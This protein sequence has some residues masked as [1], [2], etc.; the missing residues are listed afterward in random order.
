M[1]D[2]EE[3]EVFR[4]HFDEC[5]VHFREGFAARVPRG[6][7][8]SSR[9]K[10]PIADFCGV[11]IPTVTSWLNE[12]CLPTGDTLIRLMFYLELVGYKIIELERMPKTRRYFAELIGFGVLSGQEATELVGYHQTSELYIVLKGLQDA[13]KRKDEIMWDAW[14]ERR[15]ELEQKKEQ[16]RQLCS[17][18][19]IPPANRLEIEEAGHEVF[20]PPT[21]HPTAII[22]IMSA[23]LALLED[24]ADEFLKIVLANPDSADTMLHLSARLS[25]LSSQIMESA[26]LRRRQADE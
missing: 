3:Q 16:A 2:N 17:T 14:K 23:L 5:M 21:S 1:H 24:N 20:I 12:R 8:K 9:A 22:H 7:K 15:E 4:G 6:S 13:S 18:K 25:T 19:S 10:N 11:G 26:L